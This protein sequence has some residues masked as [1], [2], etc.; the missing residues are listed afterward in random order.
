MILSA[1]LGGLVAVLLMVAT[2]RWMHDQDVTVGDVAV[3]L[4]W[5]LAL[6]LSLVFIIGGYR[7][8]AR[9]NGESEPPES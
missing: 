2:D 1:Y 3:L 4:A 5:P 9:R 6:P 8:P 7:L